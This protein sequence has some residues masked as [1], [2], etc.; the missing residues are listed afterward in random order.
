[1][2]PLE[3]IRVLDFSQAMAGPAC[4]MLLGDF[5]AEV[6][7]IEPPEGESSRRWGSARAGEGGQFSGLYLAL[8]RNKSSITI[9]LKSEEGKSNIRKL[10]ASADVILENFRPGVASRLGFGY[11]DAAAIKPDIIYCSISGFGQDGPLRD[12]PGLDMLLQAYVG[13]MSITGEPGRPSVRTGPSPIDLLTG[14]HAAYGI[15]LALRER[16]KTGRGQEI[17]LSLYDTAV[18]LIGHYIADYTGGADLPGKHGPFFAFLAPYGMFAAR[19]REFY[20]GVDS[21][22]YPAFCNAID[23]GD[24]IVDPRFKTNVDRLRN[25][26]ALHEQLIPLFQTHDAQY[27]V[28]LAMKI[29]IPTSLVTD[30]GEVL[31]QEQAAAR[32]M[33]VS[34]GVDE[35]RIAGIPLKLRQTPGEIRRK[36]P[37]LG[38]DNDRILGGLENI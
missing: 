9:D 23:R 7:K 18:H 8:N 31:Q 24:L 5:G 28:E 20:L 33:I 21:R 25:R 10:I 30:I 26:D 36:P 34:S 4:G 27:W 19:D 22:S 38:E 14:A 29:G 11:A 37:R 35:V 12:R 15:S 3:G 13:H 32:E 17:D 1:M 6:V 2:A 16:D